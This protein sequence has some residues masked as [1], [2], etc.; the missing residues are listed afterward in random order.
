[1]SYNW[2]RSPSLWERYRPQVMMF[3]VT[4]AVGGAGSLLA[5]WVASL[6]D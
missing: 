3:F 2:E 5:T 1:M 6:A 4:L